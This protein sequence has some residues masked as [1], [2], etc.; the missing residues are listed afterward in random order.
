MHQAFG[1]L[2]EDG[3]AHRDVVPV[4]DMLGFRAHVELQVAHGVAAIGEKRDL[5]VE[6][7]PLR[8]ETS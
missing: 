6:L 8:L 7:H 1:I 5:L 4:E 3:E 2:V